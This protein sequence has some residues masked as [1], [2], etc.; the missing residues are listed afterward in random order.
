MREVVR[1][2]IA[3]RAL[4]VP[5]IVGVLLMSFQV[6]GL[7]AWLP[8]FYERT[9]GWGPAKVGPLLGIV[10]LIGST[11]GLFGGA[12]LAEILGKRHDDANL[13]VLFL[14]QLLPIPLFVIGPLL[15]NPWAALGCLAIGGVLSTMGA[16]GYNA[17][18]NVA[19]PNEMRSQINVMYFILQNAI[20]GSLGPT[21]VALIT[22]HI[23]HS[24]S[25]LRY[26]IVAVR[27][28]AGPLTAFFLWK[29]LAPYGRVYRQRIQE[30]A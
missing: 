29:S 7:G 27:L 8:A 14:A 23:A 18:L 4:H 19:T 21:L 12:R 11:V 1:F 20:A 17:A 25:D 28:V 6:Y 26:V 10:T 3:Q 30:G 2:V 13:R 22:D 24:E 15:P 16:A 5:L 9:Y